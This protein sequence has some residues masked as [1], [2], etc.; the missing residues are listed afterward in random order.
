M[1]GKKRRLTWRLRESLEDLEYAYDVCLVSHKYE[2]MQRKLDDLWK[3]SEKAGLVINSLKT[4]EIRVNTTVN[5]GLRLNGV[6]IKRSSDLCYLGS[7]VAEIGGTSKEVNW[8]IQ[9]AK[10]IILQIEKSVAK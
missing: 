9:K 5:Q 2:H 8:R 7:I 1:D 10:G 6:D 4:E 3:E